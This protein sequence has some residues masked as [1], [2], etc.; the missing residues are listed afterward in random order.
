MPDNMSFDM[1]CAFIT[2]YGTT[3]YALKTKAD[4]KKGETLLV[5]GASGGVGSA[6]I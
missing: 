3:Y 6:A 2:T 4:L 1:A 5:L